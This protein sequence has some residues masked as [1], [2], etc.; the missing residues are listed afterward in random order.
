MERKDLETFQLTAQKGKNRWGMHS[1]FY[2]QISGSDFP[3]PSSFLIDTL[4]CS[5]H[6]LTRASKKDESLVKSYFGNQPVAVYKRRQQNIYFKELHT[7]RRNPEE[8]TLGENNNVWRCDPT[9]NDQRLAYKI[10]ETECWRVSPLHYNRNSLQT[11]Q[12]VTSDV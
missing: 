6:S 12:H 10:R 3:W 8:Q 4:P 2:G 9:N 7:Y 11:R 1:N 5:I